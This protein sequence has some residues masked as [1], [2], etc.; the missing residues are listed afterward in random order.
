MQNGKVDTVQQ[1]LDFDWT[2]TDKHACKEVKRI[3]LD[4]CGVWFEVVLLLL[5]NME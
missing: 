4:F 5:R 2:V 3:R 1:L